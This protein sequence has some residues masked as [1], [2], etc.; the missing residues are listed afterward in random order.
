[1]IP[2]EWISLVSSNLDAMKYDAGSSVLHVRFKNGGA[3]AYDDVPPETAEGLHSA[4]SH[5]QYLREHVIGTHK[6]RRI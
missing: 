4:S 2:G 1:M 3:Y 5:G 6:H